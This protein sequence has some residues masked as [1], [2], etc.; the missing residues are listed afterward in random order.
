[1]RHIYDE[2]SWE[3]KPSS[4]PIAPVDIEVF[5]NAHTMGDPN[6]IRRKVVEVIKHPDFN[7]DT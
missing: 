5:M 1:M 3:W 7:Y 4:N 2:D 6:A